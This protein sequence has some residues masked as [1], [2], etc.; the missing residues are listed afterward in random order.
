MWAKEK[1]RGKTRG[2]KIYHWYFI[3]LI[4]FCKLKYKIR[5]KNK[6]PLG[7]PGILYFFLNLD[8]RANFF[9]LSKILIFREAPYRGPSVR[10]KERPGVEV[11]FSYGLYKQNFISP[12]KQAVAYFAARY[13]LFLLK[14]CLISKFYK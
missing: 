3:L 1:I 2:R 10:E 4:M 12:A 9:S 7:L 6:Q 13:E 14:I 5:G 11:A 8:S